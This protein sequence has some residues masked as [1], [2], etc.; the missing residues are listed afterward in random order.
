MVYPIAPN[1]HL[2][3]APN[4]NSALFCQQWQATLGGRR[5]RV[6]QV[7]LPWLLKSVH[8]HG[9]PNSAEFP[10]GASTKREFGAILSTVAGDTWRTAKQGDSG[11]PALVAEK[12]PS[13]WFTQ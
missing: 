9:L 8:P 4:G 11:Q 12:R 6:T 13:S 3:L 10:F 5:S 7:N 2:V 1:S